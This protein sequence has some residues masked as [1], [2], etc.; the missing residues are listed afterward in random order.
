MAFRFAAD[1]F[2]ARA[3]PPFAP[4]SLPSVTAADAASVGI[5][6]CSPAQSLSDGLLHDTAGDSREVVVLTVA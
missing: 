6:Q 5:S 4:P 3:L 1:S 2:S